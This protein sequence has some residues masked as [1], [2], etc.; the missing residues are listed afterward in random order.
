MKF[1]HCGLEQGGNRVMCIAAM[2]AAR[3][4]F[5]EKSVRIEEFA[6]Y[7]SPYQLRNVFV[8]ACMLI[9][10]KY[11]KREKL[12]LATHESRFYKAYIDA[13]LELRSK[14]SQINPRALFELWHQKY[15]GSSS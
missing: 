2:I 3:F 10:A 15:E 5:G 4:V 13:Y 7:V 6:V 8:S 11:V 12:C 14:S 9:E 1:Q